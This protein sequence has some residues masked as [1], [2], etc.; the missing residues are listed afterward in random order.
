MPTCPPRSEW[1]P[2]PGTSWSSECSR[3]QVRSWSAERKPSR[4]RTQG[5]FISIEIWARLR[6]PACAGLQPA[7]LTVFAAGSTE[8]RGVRVQAPRPGRRGRRRRNRPLA[9]ADRPARRRGRPPRGDPDGQDHGGDPLAGVGR[10]RAHPR[11][12]GGARARRHAAP[13]DRLDAAGADAV[14]DAPPAKVQATPLVRRLAAE[15]GVEL[16]AIA[17]T[18]PGRSDHREG[19]ARERGRP[20]RASGASRSEGYGA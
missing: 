16:A 3:R 17:G 1:R 6:T 5:A 8:A 19:R 7:G 2:R 9:R 14:E 10:G 20:E 4:P 11:R 13:R 15:L 18:G 12:G